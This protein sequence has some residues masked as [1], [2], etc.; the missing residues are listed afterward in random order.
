[1]WIDCT[2]ECPN[3][4]ECKTKLNTRFE[5]AIGHNEI[6]IS[7]DNKILKTNYAR[8]LLSENIKTQLDPSKSQL[9]FLCEQ[10]CID[11]TEVR[12]LVTSLISNDWNE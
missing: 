5:E 9:H 7:E 12:A 10:A 11:I 3:L 2:C 8:E 6:N 1:M 4:A